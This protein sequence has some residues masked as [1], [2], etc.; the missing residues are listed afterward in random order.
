[1][2]AFVLGNGTSRRGISVA[3]LRNHG[4]V[5]GC[6]AIYREVTP[7]V[8]IATDQPIAEEIQLTDYARTNRFYTRNPLPG[9]GALTLPDRWRHYSSGPNA[10]ALAAETNQEVVMLGFD[11][12]GVNGRINNIYAG[13]EY[14]E[15]SDAPT[16]F[17]GNWVSQLQKIFEFYPAVG[18]TRV[19]GPNCVSLSELREFKNYR[20]IMLD[21]FITL[22]R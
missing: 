12:G 14:Y 2:L 15:P 21:E 11:L 22:Y 16:T 20:T 19:I 1:M 9:L 18:F 4:T 7:D 13:T 6:N 3:R 17:Y 8:L 5:Y 10:I